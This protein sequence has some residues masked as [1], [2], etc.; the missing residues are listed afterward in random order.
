M[1]TFSSLKCLSVLPLA[2]LCSAIIAGQQAGLLSPPFIVS[3]QISGLFGDSHKCG[4]SIIG[5][6]AVL[7][8]AHCCDGTTKSKLKIRYGSKTFK[9]GG[10]LSSI[11]QLIIHPD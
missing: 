1:R 7:T 8:A 3:V 11:E 10:N 4:G 9:S 5:P 6:R 2:P